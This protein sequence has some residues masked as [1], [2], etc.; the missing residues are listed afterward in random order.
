MK[1]WL[2]QRR[3]IIT[4]SNIIVVGKSGQIP[5]SISCH[6][7]AIYYL[8]MLRNLPTNTLVEA[9]Y[10]D[11]S[12]LQECGFNTWV[13]KALFSVQ[14]YDIDIDLGSGASFNRYW[15]SHIYNHFKI[16]WREVQNIDKNPI[17]RNY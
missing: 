17:L 15:K 14:K 3:S 2:E 4:T 7:N 16:A 8:H 1:M 11:L 10:M 5:P 9:M 12:K 13:S 6:I